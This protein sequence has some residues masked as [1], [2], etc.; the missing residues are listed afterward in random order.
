MV[1]LEWSIQWENWLGVFFVSVL[2]V[3]GNP[4]GR[5]KKCKKVRKSTDPKIH[6][7]A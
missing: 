7:S 6:K 3:I 2:C 5:A 1:Q 4:R